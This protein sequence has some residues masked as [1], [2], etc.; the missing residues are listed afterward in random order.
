[1]NF[2]ICSSENILNDDTLSNLHIDRNFITSSKDNVAAS[3]VDDRPSIQMNTG[4]KLHRVCVERF[5]EII[6]ILIVY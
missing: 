1:M 2:N 5:Y 6:F 3:I 4:D